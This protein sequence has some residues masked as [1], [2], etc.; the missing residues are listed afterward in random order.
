MIAWLAMPALATPTHAGMDSAA[1]TVVTTSNDAD[2]GEVTISRATVDGVECFR[3]VA[4]PT[5]SRRSSS[6]SWRTSKARCG[7][8]P[9]GSP[10]RRSSRSPGTSSRITNTSTS[11][12]GRCPP[13]GTGS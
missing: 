4:K 2:A 12:A 1:W 8:R 11:P 6:R 5:S 9:P 7:G 3:G 13:T 10:K